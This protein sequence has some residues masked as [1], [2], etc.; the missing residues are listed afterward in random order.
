MSERNIEIKM[1]IKQNNL[2]YWRIAEIIGVHE[3]TILH[4]LRE[5]PLP[6]DHKTLILEAIEKLKKSEVNEE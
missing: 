3:N 4:W 5:D 2:S 6:S 1:A